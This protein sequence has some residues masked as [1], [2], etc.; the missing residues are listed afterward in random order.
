MAWVSFTYMESDMTPKARF[1]VLFT[2]EE[3]DGVD[4]GFIRGGRAKSTIMRGGQFYRGLI[5]KE[6]KV[7][8]LLMQLTELFSCR[9][10]FGGDPPPTEEEQKEIQDLKTFDK[11][12]HIFQT[13]LGEESSWKFPIGPEVQPVDPGMSSPRVQETLGNLR[14]VGHWPH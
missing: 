9:Y 12:D 13:L 14:F 2:F 8:F 11:F 4:R 1:N 10:P 3:C 6:H 5:F 7:D